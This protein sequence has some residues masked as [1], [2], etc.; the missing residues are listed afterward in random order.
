MWEEFLFESGFDAEKQKEEKKESKDDAADNQTEKEET[1]DADD[2]GLAEK[3]SQVNDKLSKA[4]AVKPIENL[5]GKAVDS[6]AK[7]RTRLRRKLEIEISPNIIEDS[8]L[9]I[10][11]ESMS[12]DK[13][14]LINEEQVAEGEKFV[15]LQGRDEHIL[16]LFCTSKQNYDEKKIDLGLKSVQKEEI[17]VDTDEADV[18]P[19]LVHMRKFMVSYK[20]QNK[21]LQDL[22]ENLMLANKR[23]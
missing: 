21:Y 15:E 9:V 13:V 20:E 2:N 5:K 14:Q 18:I 23:L 4:Y 22:N 17:M 7:P 19:E 10:I 8:E 3:W 16:E 6:S 12:K 1:L 11:E